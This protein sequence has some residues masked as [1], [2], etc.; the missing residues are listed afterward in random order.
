M[1]LEEIVA[2]LELCKKI[3]DGAF[4][5]SALVWN[6]TVCDEETGE[7]CGVHERDCCDSF[8]R[9]NQVPAPTLAEI[10]DAIDETGCS[11]SLTECDDRFRTRDALAAWGKFTDWGK[12]L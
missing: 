3:P 1:E 7:I 8:M 12:M 4:D 5:D 9:G 11:F 2:P 6:T 10:L